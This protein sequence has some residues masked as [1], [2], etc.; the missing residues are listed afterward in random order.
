MITRV[1][2]FRSTEEKQ[3]TA[4]AEQTFR[5]A[6]ARLG[7]SDPAA[8]AQTIAR[9]QTAAAALGGRARKRLGEQAVVRYAEHVLADDRLS[10]AE[11][12]TLGTL[13]E[14]V[15]FDHADLARHALATRLQIARLNDGRLPSVES[16]QLIPKPGEIV[17]LETSAA[18]MKEVSVREWRGGSQGVSFRVAKGVRYRVGATRG[19]LVTVGTQLQVDD[20]GVLSVTNHRVAFL[21][22]RKTVDMPYTRIIGMHQYADAI[23]FSLSNRQTAPLIKV[24]LDTDVLAALLNA[25]IHESEG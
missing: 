16:S 13:A 6:I 2:L 12:N 22:A 7:A 14:A 15:G 20:V 9:L 23:S 19:R 4:Q 10:E 18:L 21:G 25:A 17:H 8:A 24:T 3:R 5:D 11:E 1:K